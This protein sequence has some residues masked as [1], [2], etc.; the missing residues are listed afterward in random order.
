MQ[1]KADRG[2]GKGR[3]GAEKGR[4]GA[5]KGRQGCKEG[6]Y[7]GAKKAGTAVQREGTNS[8]QARQGIR[9]DQIAI[10]GSC[11][12]NNTGKQTSH[13]GQYLYTCFRDD[14]LQSKGKNTVQLQLSRK[15]WLDLR[16]IFAFR[17]QQIIT[18]AC[19]QVLPCM[20]RL[21][22]LGVA[23]GYFLQVRLWVTVTTG[24]RSVMAGMH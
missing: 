2:G 22:V 24:C 21:H 17:L 4:Q 7:S 13:T 8:Y 15:H 11:P 6:R 12:Q 14:L 1:T 9:A 23:C 5:E 19:V 18:E 16:C 3:Q 10:T 20:Q